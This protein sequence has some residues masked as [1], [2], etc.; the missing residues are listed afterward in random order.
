MITDSASR[1]VQ[2]TIQRGGVAI[3]KAAVDQALEPLAKSQNRQPGD[4]QRRDG[5]ENARRIRF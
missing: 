2:R 3:A 4:E 1:K 5:G